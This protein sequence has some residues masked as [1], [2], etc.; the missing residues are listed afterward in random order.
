MRHILILTSTIAGCL[1]GFGRSAAAQSIDLSR[2]TLVDLTHD[3]AAD[4]PVWPGSRD[5]FRLDTIVASPT[6]ALFRLTMNEHLATHLD[7]PRHAAGSGWTNEQIPLASL[8]APLV[9]IDVRA[10]AA[11]DRDYALS[12]ADLARHEQTFGTIPRGAIVLLRTGWAAFWNNPGR[13]FGA[14]STARPTKLHFPSFGAEAAQA[15]V[16]R[17]VALV[18]VDSPSTD[19]GAA[20]AFTV[21]GILGRANVPAVENLA[22]LDALPQTGGLLMALPIKTRGGSGGPVRVVALIPR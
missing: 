17:G 5:P 15:L 13:Y 16:S 14:D 21:H 20:P 10:Q 19:I 11:A 6:A 9:V 8:V 7:A 1:L 2:H 12:I 18:G 22:N 4:G 3:L